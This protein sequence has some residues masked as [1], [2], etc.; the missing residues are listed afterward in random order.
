MIK[1]QIQTS[2]MQYFLYG[3]NAAVVFILAGFMSITQKKI[4]SSM[5]ARQFL[6]SVAAVPLS[7]Q[8]IFL[9]AILSVALLFFLSSLYRRCIFKQSGCR[10]IILPLEICA[11]LLVMRSIN[12]AYDGVILLVVADLVSG[13]S[14]KNQRIILTFA[15]LGLYLIASYNIVD[16]QT[17][18]VPL[19]AYIAYYDQSVQGIFKAACNIFTSFN[20][21]IFVL[22]IMLLVQSQHKEKERIKSLNNQ[23]NEANEKLRLYAIEAEYMAETRER[24]RLA[25]EIHDTLG[26]ALTC[27]IAGLDACIATIDTAPEFTKKQLKTISDTARHGINDVRRSVKKLRPD[28]LEKL[29]LEDALHQMIKYF[30]NTS[31]MKIEFIHDYWPKNLRDDE[32]EVIY[33]IIQEGLTN[34]N[35]HGHASHVLITVSLKDDRLDITLKDNG[36]GCPKPVMG[37]GLRHMHERL[38]LL[39]GTLEYKSD[40][41]FI[42]KA[43]IPIN[44]EGHYD[45]KNNDSR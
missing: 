8:E 24:N 40:N 42:I 17:K 21:I 36:I 19:E 14:G 37:F 18:M 26:H 27:I 10:Y 32:E 12:M 15:M 16:L 43:A 3:F 39:K 45:D 13:Y 9:F 11:C 34:A 30:S 33:R 29:S 7:S 2:A 1:P 5:V 23:L 22:Y 35:Q 38:A 41:G 20:M 44:Q 31:G 25:R 28:D 6:D 4:N